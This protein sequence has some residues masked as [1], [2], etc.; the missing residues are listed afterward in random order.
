MENKLNLL[1]EY[2]ESKRLVS[3]SRKS[4]SAPVGFGQGFLNKEQSDNIGTSPTLSWPGFSR[5]VFCSL[6]W[7]QHWRNGAF[8]M[9]VTSLRM[10]RKSWKGFHRR[11]PGMFPNLLQSLAEVYCSTRQPFWRKCSLHNWIV[12]RFSGMKCFREH[13]EFA[14]DYYTP[15]TPTVVCHSK[16]YSSA[17]A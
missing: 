6:D 10:R 16:T 14:R 2:F 11:L 17:N 9:L 8:V 1:L 7:N 3:P 12:L 15:F 5:F 13:V 4:C